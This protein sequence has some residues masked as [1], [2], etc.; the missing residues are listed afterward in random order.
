MTDITQ[1]TKASISTPEQDPSSNFSSGQNLNIGASISRYDPPRQERRNDET[2]ID[3]ESIHERGLLPVLPKIVARIVTNAVSD[4]VEDIFRTP[5][6]KFPRPPQQRTGLAGT[7]YGTV[8]ALEEVTERNLT[9]GTVGIGGAIARTYPAVQ[10]V[11]MTLFGAHFVVSFPE[12]IEKMKREVTTAVERGDPRN[13]A[14]ILTHEIL[15]ISLL[16]GVLPRLSRG[17]NSLL[18][19][20]PRSQTGAVIDL[21]KVKASYAMSKGPP[22]VSDDLMK[23]T[24]FSQAPIKGDPLNNLRNPRLYLGQDNGNNGTG[25]SAMRALGLQNVLSETTIPKPPEIA[26]FDADTQ[27][28]SQRS[29]TSGDQIPTEPS[30]EDQRFRDIARKGLRLGGRIWLGPSTLMEFEG[31]TLVI[32]AINADGTLRLRT[33]E[34][35]VVHQAVEPQGVSP[36]PTSIPLHRAT[37]EETLEQLRRQQEEAALAAQRI[38]EARQRWHLQPDS[39]YAQS[40]ATIHPEILPAVKSIRNCDIETIASNSGIGQISGKGWGSYIQIQLIFDGD[41]EVAKKID[42]FAKALTSELRNELGNPAISLQLVS[43]ERW[44]ENQETTSMEITRLPIYRL[45][46]VGYTNDEEIRY[47]WKKVAEK[48]TP[49]VIE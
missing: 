10:K 26:R 4:A 9:P 11:L 3:A 30:I 35:K 42:V 19:Y 46:L 22:R 36:R 7:V 21:A 48:F 27:E 18:R 20:D 32:D 2:F 6:V 14:N 12:E 17:G 45:Q 31:E 15:R 28:P 34:G 37:S 29:A 43:A 41:L 8:E 49:S 16:M 23:P 33:A 44:V 25:Q 1:D 5:L 47:A 39:E 13:A 24:A 38:Q 40:E